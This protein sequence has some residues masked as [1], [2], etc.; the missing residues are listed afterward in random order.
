MNYTLLIVMALSLCAASLAAAQDPRTV[1]VFSKQ[2]RVIDY[3]V[4]PVLAP[5][6]SGKCVI[7]LASKS[8]V[9]VRVNGSK[10]TA[11]YP[12]RQP[13]HKV[14]QP[15]VMDQ[16]LARELL[17]APAFRAY[18][19]PKFGISYGYNGQGM[20]VFGG[21]LIDECPMPPLWSG[22]FVPVSYVQPYVNREF[23]ARYFAVIGP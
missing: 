11:Y 15:M 9:A 14:N 18:A 6:A 10:K 16:T 21:L 2:H 4:H 8:R 13:G 23:L 20:L 17:N 3:D 12:V 19:V 1:D 7:D 22:L 5:L